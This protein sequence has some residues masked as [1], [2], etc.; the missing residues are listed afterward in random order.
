M[1]S[2]TEKEREGEGERDIYGKMEERCSERGER[3]EGRKR[4]TGRERER[5]LSY[6]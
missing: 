6:D 5:Q 2:D 1:K 3:E 4:E